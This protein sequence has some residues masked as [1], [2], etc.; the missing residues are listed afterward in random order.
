MRG[1]WGDATNVAAQNTADIDALEAQW[2][3]SASDVPRGLRE[4]SIDFGHAVGAAVFETSKDDGEH[5]AYLTNASPDYEP[6]VGPGL[7]VPLPGQMAVQPFWA[8]RM[9]AF[10][11][12]AA[13]CN[14]S[15]PVYSETPGSTFYDQALEVYQT[16][17]HLTPEQLTI[18]RFWA[19][20]PGSIG[21]PGHCCPRRARCWSRLGRI[22]R[23]PP[24]R[25]PGLESPTPTRSFPARSA[26]CAFDRITPFT[27]IRSLIDPAYTTPLPTP[28]FPEYTSAHSVQTAAALTTLQALF[29]DVGYTD[30]THDA[31]GFAPRTF[32][33]LTDS[34]NETGISVSTVAIRLSRG[35]RRWVRPGTLRLGEGQRPALEA[36]ARR[37]A[38]RRTRTDLGEP[39]PGQ[40]LGQLLASTRG[41]PPPTPASAAPGGPPCRPPAP[42]APASGGTPLP[43]APAGAPA[44]R[45]APD[46][47]FSAI[48]TFSYGTPQRS[49]HS[50]S[51]RRS[52]SSTSPSAAA[53]AAIV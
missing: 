44:A 48:S 45:R 35:H 7:W 8:D 11:S 2:E 13:S 33:T 10:V 47:A 15:P 25:S 14:P 24:K 42:S 46:P 43:R 19:D 23:R 50:F 28:P 26:K 22:S 27:Y 36:R 12:P 29:G 17:T 40:Q 32:A 38:R 21:G 39:E 1:L 5:R 16:S 18:A 6:P 31:D 37:G 20:G 52:R 4:R 34:M 53:I 9:T 3:A 30:H 49:A 41:A 51:I